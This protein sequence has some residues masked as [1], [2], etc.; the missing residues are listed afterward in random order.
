MRKEVVVIGLLIVIT[1]LL[2]LF[3]RT[4]TKD[5]TNAKNFIQEHLRA[6]YPDADVIEVINGEGVAPTGYVSLKARVTRQYATPCP[7]RIHEYYNVSVANMQ[8]FVTGAS[9]YIT[10]G[11]KICTGETTCILAFEEEAIIA[12]HTDPGTDQVV[13]YLQNYPDAKPNVPVTF[14]ADYNGQGEAWNVTWVSQKAPFSI[15]VTLLKND[16]KVVETNLIG[17]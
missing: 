16:N 7:E 3:P 8:N 4:D 11:C 12:S 5:Y 14:L 6:K 1:L 9:E 10:R 15:Y 13:Q 2:V 17:K